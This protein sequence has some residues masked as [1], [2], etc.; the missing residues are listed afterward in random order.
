L[1]KS[2]DRI[3]ECDAGRSAAWPRLKPRFPASQPSCVR[4][5]W[6]RVPDTPG[7]RVLPLP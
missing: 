2:R 1:T 4:R 3:D 7:S 5:S 6:R